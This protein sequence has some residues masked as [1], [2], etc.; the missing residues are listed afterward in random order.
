MKNKT[1]NKLYNIVKTGGIQ[2]IIAIIVV[3]W[4][5]VKY[6]WR[7]P[8]KNKPL[9]DFFDLSFFVTIMTT[10]LLTILTKL[11]SNAVLNI[12]EDDV[13]LTRDYDRLVKSYIAPLYEFNNQN[14]DVS[15]LRKLNSIKKN[16]NSIY[17]FPVIKDFELINSTIEIED[18]DNM[19]ELPDFVKQN[20]VELLNS[21]ETSDVFNQL[22]VRIKDWMKKGNIFV[23]KCERTSYFNSLVTNRA[24]DFKLNNGL[25][26]REAIEYGPFIKNLKDSNLSNHL[27]FNGFVESS[28]GFIPFIKRSKNLSIG[29][30]TYGNSIGASLKTKYAL[31]DKKKITVEQLNTAIKKEIHDELGL[32]MK[33]IDSS[34]NI[35][36]YFYAAYRDIVEGGKPQLFFYLKM[37]LTK[38]EMIKSFQKM[39]K[40]KD[41][42]KTLRIDGTKIVWINKDD[43]K[44]VALCSDMMIC[45]NKKYR[46]M[47]SAAA[48]VGFAIDMHLL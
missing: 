16:K 15:N 19:Y 18:S 22:N 2:S 42:K 46:M 36:N 31:N 3:S 7:H 27:G 29:K 45:K 1:R 34:V 43:L 5:V 44:K 26:I 6:I 9:E 48:C 35:N 12:L 41:S 4:Q 13:K 37:T 32:E 23:I 25:S 33:D 11:I 14:A 24:M 21:H 17:K 20:Y 47:P 8:F 38:N 39:V 10:F 40:E 28:D 30:R